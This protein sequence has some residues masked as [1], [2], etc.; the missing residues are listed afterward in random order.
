MDFQA[1]KKY[2]VSNTRPIKLGIGIVIAGVVIFLT[3]IILTAMEAEFAITWW[4]YLLGLVGIFG[5]IAI[6]NNATSGRSNE[7]DIKNQL[8]KKNDRLTEHNIQKLGLEKRLLKLPVSYCFE[9]FDYSDPEDLL[10]RRGRDSRF[11]SSRYVTT[12][13]LFTVDRLVIVK[14][15]F[16]L[17]SEESKEVEDVLQFAYTSLDECHI[18]AD[19]SHVFTIDKASVEVPTPALILNTTESGTILDVNI[20]DKPDVRDFVDTLNK[21]I[22]EKK[23][24][25]ERK[26]KE[27]LKKEKEKKEEQ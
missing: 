15:R 25:Q 16:S 9:S 20:D 24:E 8:Q 12:C 27:R 5:G 14:N 13:F 2:F 19:R 4:I 18:D 21:F 17:V 26:E 23:D 1:N 11:R 10:V 7:N 22:K 3:A 6:I